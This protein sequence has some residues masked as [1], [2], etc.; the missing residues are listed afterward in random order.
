LLNKVENALNLSGK[1]C[2]KCEEQKTVE[3]NRIAKQQAIHPKIKNSKCKGTTARH[4]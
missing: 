4:T 3:M 2:Q 1:T